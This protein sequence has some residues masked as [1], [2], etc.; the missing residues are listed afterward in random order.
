MSIY[1]SLAAA[2]G[3]LEVLIAFSE[4]LKP[5]VIN[6]SRMRQT[7]YFQAAPLPDFSGR[8]LHSHHPS[9]HRLLHLMWS[10]VSG[11]E[12]GGQL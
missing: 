4:K 6:S 5:T 9:C 12:G 1:G 8:D 2:S 11:E 10:P 3:T 7:L